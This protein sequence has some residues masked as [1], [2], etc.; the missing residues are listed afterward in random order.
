MKDLM[1]CSSSVPKDLL[2]LELAILPTCY[3]IQIRRLLS[4]HHLL[5]Q[6]KDSLLYKFFMEQLTNPTH[7]DWVSQ[8]LQELED[9]NIKLVIKDI[10]LLS[11]EQYKTVIKEAVYKKAFSDLLLRKQSRQ[12]E[13]AK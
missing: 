3:V 7:R 9:L 2:Y 4:F 13:H 1:N 12:S 10:E 11:K 8:V 5:N 6:R